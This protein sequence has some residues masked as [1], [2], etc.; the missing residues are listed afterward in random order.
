MEKQLPFVGINIGTDVSNLFRPN[1]QV[2]FLKSQ[3]I[4]CICLYDADMALLVAFSNT[5]IHMVLG[6]PNN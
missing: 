4:T 6:M 5:G 3:Q 1:D 2:A